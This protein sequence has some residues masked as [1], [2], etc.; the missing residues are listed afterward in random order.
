M[1]YNWAPEHGK[2]SFY[3]DRDVPYVLG[4]HAETPID[5]LLERN[6]LKRR[7]IDHWIV[8]SGGKKVI[9]AIKY[10][11]GITE[12]DVR[13]TVGILR[14]FGNLGSGSFLFS[15]QRLLREGKIQPGDRAVMMT[16]GPGSTFET[17]LLEW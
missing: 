6:G 2:F 5:G 9:D 12:Y 13:H 16:M 3:L 8:H 10:N 11:I 15:Y 7:D 14:Q 4:I 1:R 17:A